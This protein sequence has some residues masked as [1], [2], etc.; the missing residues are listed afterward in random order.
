VVCSGSSI[1]SSLAVLPGGDL[2]VLYEK[3]NYKQIV[4]ARVRVADVK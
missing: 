1:Y 2:G 4:F 3:D